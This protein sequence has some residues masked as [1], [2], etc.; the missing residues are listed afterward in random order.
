MK[1]LEELISLVEHKN[2]IDLQK[3]RETYNDITWLL[4]E[5]KAEV[6]EVK[7][8]IKEQNSPFLEDELGDVLWALFMLIEKL[9]DK[10][11]VSSHENIIKRALKKYQERIFALKAKNLEEDEKIWQAVKAKQKRVLQ[12]EKEQYNQ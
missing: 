11:L 2:K 7:E 10:N 4:N 12:E 1:E 6:D 9:K 8:E 3:G 5:I